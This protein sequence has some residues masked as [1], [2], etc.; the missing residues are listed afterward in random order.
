MVTRFVKNQGAR[1]WT[2]S[3]SPTKNKY[4]LLLCNGGPGCCDYLEP[5]AEMVSDLVQV[6]RFEQR[7]CGRSDALPPYTVESCI[8]DLE[9]IR[10]S[11]G[12]EQW[13]VGGHSWGADLALGYAL[14]HPHRVHA[15]ICISGGRI[16]ND[17]EWHK[18]YEQKSVEVGELLPEFEVPPNLEVNQQVGQSWKRY[19]QRPTLLRELAEFAPPTLFV[20]GKQDIR[21][22]WPQEQ[23]ASL[24]PN[25]TLDL[26][27]DAPHAIWLTHPNE[28][29]SSLRRFLTT[30]LV[31]HNSA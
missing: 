8:T 25:A 7:G 28:L 18:I 30:L 24:M 31:Q 14:A 19:I 29:R 27:T 4:P 9:A 1:L 11:Y 23:L 17:R 15:L 3:S 20:Y 6:V 2:T 21:P 22:S 13:L 5:V 16:V 26:L 10:Q 12:F